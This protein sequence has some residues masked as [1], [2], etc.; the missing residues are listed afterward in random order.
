[1]SDLTQES[2]CVLYHF[3]YGALTLYGRPFQARSPMREE[4][5]IGVL[6]PPLQ[7]TGLGYSLFARHY[8]GNLVIDFFSSVTEMFQFTE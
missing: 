8:W 3:A 5:D 7:V 1:M 4:S 2:R 6:Q